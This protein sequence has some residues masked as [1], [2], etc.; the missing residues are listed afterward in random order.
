MRKKRGPTITDRQKEDIKS[1]AQAGWHPDD[2]AQGLGVS[3]G[4]VYKFADGGLR[5]TKKRQA[6]QREMQAADLGV[7]APVIES[8]IRPLTAF[9]K[10]TGRR[11]REE[12]RDANVP[13]ELQVIECT[14]AS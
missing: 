5:Y 1:L 14:P 7:K 10:M 3:V 13:G 8:S 9:E 4:S 12:L 11:K 2:I 6:K